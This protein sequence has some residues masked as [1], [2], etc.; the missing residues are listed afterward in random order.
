M[1]VATTTAAGVA[2]EARV[3]AML[4]CLP[5]VQQLQLE[6]L[7]QLLAT[8][9][10]G[11]HMALFTQLLQLQAAQ[12]LAE[13]AAAALLGEACEVRDAAAVNAVLFQLCQLP[14]ARHVAPAAGGSLLQAALSTQQ[15]DALTC[16]WYVRAV[17]VTPSS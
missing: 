13:E 16:K 7:Q 1:Q 5:A 9:I 8:A 15:L 2:D 12:M 6:Q 14:G 4:N 11:R 3:A 17:L 10:Q